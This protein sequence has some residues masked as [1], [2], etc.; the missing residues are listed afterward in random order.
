LAFLFAFVKKEFC[1]Y[2]QIKTKMENKRYS[3]LGNYFRNIAAAGLMA[4]LGLY[5]SGCASLPV[6]NTSSNNSDR[7]MIV[8]TA[9]GPR[10]VP[11]PTYGKKPEDLFKASKI[12]SP[13]LYGGV[14]SINQG[15]TYLTERKSE[16]S[17]N[18]AN[19]VSTNT[20]VLSAY[21]NKAPTNKLALVSKVPTNTL[22]YV[23]V[24]TNTPVIPKAA[25]PVIP[26]K[27]ILNQENLIRDSVITNVLNK[28]LEGKLDSN[29]NSLVSTN[30]P[31]FVPFIDPYVVSS[32][33]ATLM[34]VNTSVPNNFDYGPKEER[35][36]F[37]GLTDP[38]IVYRKEEDSK[39]HKGKV[40]PYW[41]EK[42]VETTVKAL[43]Y[44][45]LGYGVSKCFGGSEG[46]KESSQTSGQSSQKSKSFD[47]DSE[48]ITGG[49]SGG[50]GGAGVI[51]GTGGGDSGEI[52]GGDSGGQGG[53]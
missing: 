15:F 16:P 29:T 12:T 4:A 23:Q 30:F 9:W 51:I 36:F 46:D 25:V 21:S 11:N 33:R 40:L 5:S 53:N 2:I 34:A 6:S 48:E 3:K 37:M 7:D 45:L 28:S 13:R 17:V 20:A 14:F 39:D 49:D 18:S 47:D 42:P 50:Q 22:G 1:V 43:V 8:N 10:L 31:N 41:R 19:K 24:P 38:F 32:N 44:T 27:V 26:L 52:T 35:G